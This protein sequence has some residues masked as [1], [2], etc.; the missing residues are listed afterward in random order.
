[1]IFKKYV[2][3]L[4]ILKQCFSKNYFK[5]LVVSTNSKNS[6]SSSSRYL[7]HNL[8][9]PKKYIE[10]LQISYYCLITRDLSILSEN[11]VLTYRLYQEVG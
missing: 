7:H 11:N 4:N 2:G 9:I 1:M 5:Y 3:H 6:S 8:H 10:I